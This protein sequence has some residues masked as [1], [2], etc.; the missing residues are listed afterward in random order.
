[1]A[2][3]LSRTCIPRS[4]RDTTTGRRWRPTRI[5]RRFEATSAFRKYCAEF[6]SRPARPPGRNVL[7]GL[8]L[9]DEPVDVFVENLER[10][11]AAAENRIVEPADVELRPELA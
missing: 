6:P 1:T 4:R 10:H 8:L 11:R 3:G 2:R 9:R 5:S 7:L